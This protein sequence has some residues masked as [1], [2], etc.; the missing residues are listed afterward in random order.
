[1]SLKACN[2]DAT[3]PAQIAPVFPSSWEISMPDPP[4]TAVNAPSALAQPRLDP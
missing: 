1:L 2:H 4:I 3:W